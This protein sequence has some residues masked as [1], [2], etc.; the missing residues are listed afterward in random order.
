[1]PISPSLILSPVVGTIANVVTVQTRGQGL[2]AAPISGN[3]TAITPLNLTITPKRAGNRIILEWIVNGEGHWDVAYIVTRNDI[4]LADTTNA[5][6][7]RWACIVTQPYDTEVNS[8]PD[9]AVV[10]TIDMNSLGVLSTYR[11]HVRS[12]GPTAHTLFLNRTAGSF[13]ID[14]HETCLSTGIAAE[15]WT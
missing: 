1:M 8:T 4:L 7:D 12:S 13:S 14:S 11:L 5:A 3:G 6:N 9:N 15:I 10:K 2:F